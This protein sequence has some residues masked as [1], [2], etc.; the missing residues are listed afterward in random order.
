MR[1]AHRRRTRP[2]AGECRV[3]NQFT[4]V[5]SVAELAEKVSHAAGELGVDVTIDTFRT[6]AS[7]S[8]STT[9]TRRTPSC[10]RLGLQPTLLS[11]TL[12][13]SMLTT[14]DR[15]KHRVIPEGIDPST[16]WRGEPVAQP[17]S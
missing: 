13:E 12:I 2:T 6:R 3:Y 8:R 5:F 4:E 14:I 11:E 9:T 16:Q 7:S 17:A 15:Y 10:R 1:R